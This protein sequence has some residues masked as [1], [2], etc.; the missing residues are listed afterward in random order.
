[1]P[2]LRS[3]GFAFAVLA[4]AA[5]PLHAQAAAYV[6]TDSTTGYV[7]EQSGA[8][9]KLQIGSLTK[10]AAA[11]VVLDWQAGTNA[12]LNQLATVSPNDPPSFCAHHP[13][14]VVEVRPPGLWDTSREPYTTRAAPTPRNRS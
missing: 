7:L 2:Y 8:Q 14:G 9:K 10:V 3:F 11:M 4:L 12:D 13:Y 1:M 6:I 5:F